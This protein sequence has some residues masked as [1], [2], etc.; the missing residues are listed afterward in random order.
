MLERSK[1]AP[2]SLKIA[3]PEFTKDNT[4]PFWELVRRFFAN[5]GSI[6]NLDIAAHSS[7]K[8]VIAS[9][10]YKSDAP[11]LRTLK[12]SGHPLR[13]KNETPL[14]IFKHLTTFPLLRTL[15]LC[16]VRL[17]EAL[18]YIP[19]LRK[20]SI[21]SPTA[22][23]HCGTTISWLLKALPSTP[24]LHVLNVHQLLLDPLTHPALRTPDPVPLKEL[25]SF[26][27]IF[28]DINQ[29][30]LFDSIDF[31]PTTVVKAYFLGSQLGE[32]APES[33]SPISRIVSRV[34]SSDHVASAA[35]KTFIHLPTALGIDASANCPA[36]SISLPQSLPVNN[37]T[38]YNRL[39][40]ALA[41]IA[42]QVSLSTT[43]SP[44]IYPFIPGVIRTL[45]MLERVCFPDDYRTCQL[46]LRALIKNPDETTL[47]CPG[48]REI[49]L[50]YS[51]FGFESV[52][53]ATVNLLEAVVRERKE[54]GSPI[55]S[56]LV[57][58]GAIDDWKLK[59]EFRE[60]LD[61]IRA[62]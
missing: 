29:S 7:M 8:Q 23:I 21:V 62:A 5:L 2:L 53:K 9:I 20:L 60:L 40:N 6:R 3:Y 14:G 1:E 34:A 22:R 36:V 33:I 39:F 27:I 24:N 50:S 43:N 12:I 31:P 19:Q 32:V 25:Q 59:F 15:E 55:E 37:L 11:I 47:P 57:S 54:L 38:Q 42:R 48:L 52:D 49:E 56:V 30:I 13:E 10:P 18:P 61:V 28:A 26:D 41:P 4:E 44:R 45:N 35:C 16:Y 17:P 46:F 58:K 51:V